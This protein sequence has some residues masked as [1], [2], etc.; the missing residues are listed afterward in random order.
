MT[1]NFSELQ[2]KVDRLL[3]NVAEQNRRA[4]QL[5]YDP[6]PRDVQLP[7]IDEN[8]NLTTVTIPNR[9]KILTEFNSWKE[10]AR[11]EFNSANICPNPYLIDSDNS[12]IPD[13]LAF[14][15]T[16]VLSTTVLTPKKDGNS[17]EQIAYRLMAFVFNG[18]PD[19]EIRG[20]QGTIF[21]RFK[22]LKL[23]AEV[24]TTPGMDAILL[25]FPANAFIGRGQGKQTITNGCFYYLPDDYTG[26]L[27]YRWDSPY[28][29]V[30]IRPDDNEAFSP[31]FHMWLEV[32]TLKDS[33]NYGFIFAARN[34]ANTT[35]NVTLYVAAPFTIPG[36]SY[37]F[38][39]TLK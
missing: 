8:G 10:N 24:T 18:D 5:F 34:A 9:A 37:G 20:N 39:V 31:G 33:S 35:F 32:Q 27:K 14:A 15:N 26:K 25:F 6:T 12:G 3:Y 2:Q 38:G 23:K 19:R 36:F 30:F 4:Y 29:D 22:V 16:K 17:D 7:Q 1:F 28:G 13:G 21:N 11:I